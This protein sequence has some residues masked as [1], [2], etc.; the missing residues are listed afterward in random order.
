[1]S[2][3]GFGIERPAAHSAGELRNKARYLVLIESAG[4]VLA[5]MFTES[6]ELAADFDAGSS[7]VAVMT[8]GLQPTVGACGPEWDRALGGHGAQERAAA[9]VFTLDV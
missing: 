8:Q 5:M 9:Q 7:E 4:T 2:D 3:R 6:R 1:M